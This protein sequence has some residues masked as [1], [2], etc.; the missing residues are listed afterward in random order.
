MNSMVS[1]HGITPPDHASTGDAAPAL[2]EIKISTEVNERVAA[3]KWNSRGDEEPTWCDHHCPSPPALI[4]ATFLGDLLAGGSSALK[5]DMPTP[6]LASWR[7]NRSRY[8]HSTW[9]IRRGGLRPAC[10]SQEAASA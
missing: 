6:A 7:K 8:S 4:V 9:P 2:I 3:A 10:G 5:T 1:E